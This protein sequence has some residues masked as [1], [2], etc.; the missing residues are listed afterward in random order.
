MPEASSWICFVE[1]VARGWR[2]GDSTGLLESL[3]FSE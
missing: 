1:V 2:Q 3:F